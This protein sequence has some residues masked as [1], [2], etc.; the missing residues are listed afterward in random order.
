MSSFQARAGTREAKGDAAEGG[1]G[2]PVRALPGR[3]GI[4]RGLSP[5]GGALS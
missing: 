3:A 1:A 4:P 5:Q 2:F